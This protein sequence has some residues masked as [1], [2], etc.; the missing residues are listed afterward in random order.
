MLEKNKTATYDCK[1]FAFVEMEKMK[2][3]PFGVNF[4]ILYCYIR[5]HAN[6]EVC[7]CCSILGPMTKIERA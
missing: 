7:R 2:G 3:Y 6:V 1:I 5:Y 4:Y